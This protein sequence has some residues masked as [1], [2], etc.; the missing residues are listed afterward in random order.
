M[1]L[2]KLWM[3]ITRAWERLI[4]DKL[5]YCFVQCNGISFEFGNSYLFNLKQSTIVYLITNSNTK[6]LI[7]QLLLVKYQQYGDRQISVH[8]R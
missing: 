6:T 8:Q 2:Q 3:L 7:Q 5:V 4:S 1:R